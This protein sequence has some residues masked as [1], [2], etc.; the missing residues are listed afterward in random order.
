EPFSARSKAG[1]AKLTSFPAS[2]GAAPALARGR[3][4][5]GARPPAALPDVG[6]PS[7]HSREPRCWRSSAGGARRAAAQAGAPLIRVVLAFGSLAPPAGK[8]G[9]PEGSAE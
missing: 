6:D 3:L 8:H 2:R 5:G 1:G 7:V 9:S 4:R